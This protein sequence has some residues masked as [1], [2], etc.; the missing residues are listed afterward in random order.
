MMRLVNQ[1][2][3]L[4]QLNRLSTEIKINVIYLLFSMTKRFIES[5]TFASLILEIDKKAKKEKGP[6]RPFTGK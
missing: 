5:G 6:G 4:F 3:A 1:V 2:N